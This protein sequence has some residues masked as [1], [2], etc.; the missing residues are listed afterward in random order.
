MLGGYFIRVKLSDGCT[1]KKQ[2]GK[3]PINNFNIFL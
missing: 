2:N 3:V 1:N